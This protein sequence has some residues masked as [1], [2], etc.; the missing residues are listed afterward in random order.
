MQAHLQ[1]EAASVLRLQSRIDHLDGFL[2]QVRPLGLALVILHMIQLQVSHE[3]H[4]LVH[5]AFLQQLQTHQQ[6]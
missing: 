6:P 4:N 3:R 2:S 5:S 1:L